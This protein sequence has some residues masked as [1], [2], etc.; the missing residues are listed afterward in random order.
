MGPSRWNYEPLWKFIAWTT[1]TL[2]VFISP[3]KIVLTSYFSSFRSATSPKPQSPWNGH[4][5]S[6]TSLSRYSHNKPTTSVPKWLTSLSSPLANDQHISE[7]S[8][9]LVLRITAWTF[10]SNIFRVR[11][12]R[13]LCLIPLE[14]PFI[15][16]MYRISCCWRMRNWRWGIRARSEVIKLRVILPTLL[17]L[18][19]NT[20]GAPGAQY[21]RALQLSIPIVQPHWILACHTEKSFAHQIYGIHFLILFRMVP[22]GSFYLGA[23]STTSSPA[24]RR[25]ES[26]SQASSPFP[27]SP[28]SNNSTGV[29]PDPARGGSM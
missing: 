8:F 16:A 13:T 24:F 9:Q 14:Y 3:L 17:R 28:P 21:Q 10:P 20:S 25:P 27:T 5:H 26:M 15:L 7:Y 29:S 6:Q 12:G 19:R 1:Q 11:T 22:I 4:P 2:F 18:G 23:S